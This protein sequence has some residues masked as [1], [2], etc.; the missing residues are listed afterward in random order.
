MG[1][2]VTEGTKDA[3]LERFTRAAMRRYSRRGV[4]GL[5]GKAGLAAVIV[6]AGLNT[7]ATTAEALGCDECW[8]ACSGC[9]SG[10]CC[11]CNTLCNCTCSPCYTCTP[12]WFQAH[13]LWILG[14]IPNC[15]CPGCIP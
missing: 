12:Q 14:Y 9:Q 15:T 1:T 6:T 4:F 3:V 8:G 11:P 10:C 2:A 13:M 5:L 7:Q